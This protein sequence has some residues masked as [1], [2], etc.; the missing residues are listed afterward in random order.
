MPIGALNEPVPNTPVS[1]L[2]V[3]HDPKT[4]CPS[5]L[6]VT[7]LVQLF[8]T[9]VVTALFERFIARIAPLPVSATNNKALSEEIASALGALNLTLVPMPS[10]QPATPAPASVVTAPVA[11]TTAL[12]AWL[13]V[14]ATYITVGADPTLFTAMPLGV[15]NLAAWETKPV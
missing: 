14:S 10:A 6:V 9:I 8:P 11:R 1:G 12:I 7:L 15:L 4:V 13:S 2:L 5:V 3:S